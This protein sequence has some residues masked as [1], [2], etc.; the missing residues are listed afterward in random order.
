MLVEDLNTV[1]PSLTSSQ[2]CSVLSRS[3]ADVRQEHARLLGWKQEPLFGTMCLWFL[4]VPPVNVEE[5]CL[6]NLS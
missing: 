4:W 1:S 5:T 6:H 2:A 3:L